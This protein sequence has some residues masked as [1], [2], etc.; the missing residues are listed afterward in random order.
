M[1]AVGAGI[2]TRGD[3]A[4]RLGVAVVGLGGA[5]AT[6]A[7]A[8]V[9]LIRRGLA[10]TEGLP[11]AGLAVGGMVPYENLHFGGWDLSGD[12]L[13]SAATEHGVLETVGRFR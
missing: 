4:R 13:A 8:G 7:V 10:G 11:L 12:D 3:S 2:G 9:E 6:T 5:V 1:N